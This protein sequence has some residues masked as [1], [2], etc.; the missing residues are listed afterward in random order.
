[1]DMKEEMMNDA[2]DDVIGDEEDDEERLV[3][4]MSFSKYDI[5]QRESCQRACPLF[6]PTIKVLKGGSLVPWSPNIFAIEPRAQSYF[7]L[8]AQTK[9]LILAKLSPKGNHGLL[10]PQFFHLGGLEPI[11]LWSAALEP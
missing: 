2:I 5:A 8:R 4:K 11:I 10:E 1:M 3:M 6:V 9:M 7:L